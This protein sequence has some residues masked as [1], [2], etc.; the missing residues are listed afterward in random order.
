MG[1]CAVPPGGSLRNRRL[2]E[3]VPYPEGVERP[4]TRGDC[5]D[6]ERPCPWVS[7]RYHLRVD[8]T[9]AGNVKVDPDFLE[10]G[11]GPTCALDYADAGS[12][13]LE[14]VGAAMDL[15]RERVRQIEAIALRKIQ[16][17]AGERMRELERTEP[18]ERVPLPRGFRW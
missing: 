16:K 9:F 2:L 17:T 10:R 8:T 7:C 18:V 11:D 5:A 13:T 6:G 4:R 14:E 3:V 1:A 12:H 15:T